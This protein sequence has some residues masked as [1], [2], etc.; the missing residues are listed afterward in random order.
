MSDLALPKYDK[1]GK[2]FTY[3]NLDH[4]QVRQLGS[5]S[6]REQTVDD[7]LGQVVSELRVELRAERRASDVE[8]RLAVGGSSHLGRD[9]FFETRYFIRMCIPLPI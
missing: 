2:H 5:L 6:D 3:H 8:E 4:V 1:K 9:G 7:A